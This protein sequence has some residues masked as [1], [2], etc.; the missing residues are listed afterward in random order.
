VENRLSAGAFIEKAGGFS[1][2][3]VVPLT[4]LIFLNFHPMKIPGFIKILW[5]NGIASEWVTA[6]I[7]F[8]AGFRE[9]PIF[10]KIP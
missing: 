4:F 5:E 8:C 1:L 6:Y 10:Q 7:G 2:L 3:N 9:R